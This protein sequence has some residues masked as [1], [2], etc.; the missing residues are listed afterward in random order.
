MTPCNKTRDQLTFTSSL[1]LLLQHLL[2]NSGSDCDS[3]Q[4]KRHLSTVEIKTRDLT[5]YDV[6]GGIGVS[7][8]HDVI[9]KTGTEVLPVHITDHA[10]SFLSKYGMDSKKCLLC[11]DE[12]F[13]Y[14]HYTKCCGKLYHY[15]CLMRKTSALPPWERFCPNCKAVN[16]GE[17]FKLLPQYEELLGKTK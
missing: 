13:A 16:L 12:F 2:S 5:S 17:P 3:P 9:K 14:R 15:V 6:R 7:P 10:D 4:G 11:S 1:L 8:I